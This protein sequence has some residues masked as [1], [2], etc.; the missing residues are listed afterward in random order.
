MFPFFVCDILFKL[1]VHV[2]MTSAVM[3]C[4]RV[5]L[6]VSVEGA[7]KWWWG[8][9]GVSEPDMS[10]YVTGVN[11]GNW[12]IRRSDTLSAE[13]TMLYSFLPLYLLVEETVLNCNVTVRNLTPDTLRHN[14]V[15]P[16]RITHAKSPSHHAVLQGYTRA[17][18]V[19]F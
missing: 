15:F 6:H 19:F 11:G 4:Q 8:Q 10:I 12:E 1:A 17:D 9:L 16:P 2:H 5:C 14:H 3:K 13:E 18:M 7:G